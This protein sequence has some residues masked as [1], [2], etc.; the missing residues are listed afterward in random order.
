MPFTE[1]SAAA[2]RA[3]LAAARDSFATVG[4]ERS[5]IRSIAAAAGV[6]SSMVIRYFGSKSELFVAT[7]AD[8]LPTPV[9][10][11]VTE[12]GARFAEAFVGYWEGSDCTSASS[13]LR[14]APTHPDAAAQ[15]Q[16]IVDRMIAGPVR[17]ALPDDPAVDRRIA[18]LVAVLVGHIYARY[19]LRLEPIASLPV[20][21]LVA[22]LADTVQYQVSDQRRGRE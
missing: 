16:H 4:Y 12:F 6:H 21:A 1:R 17:A 2:R 19:I 11:D 13:L 18:S 20:D 22:G 7:V 9:V 5:T 8:E 15:L 3:I 14:V 10:G